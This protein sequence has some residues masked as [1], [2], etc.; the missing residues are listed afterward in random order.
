M[1]AGN[2]NQH[3]VPRFYLRYF[4]TPE[5]RESPHPQVWAF[6]IEKGDEYRTGTRNVAAERDLYAYCGSDLDKRF[7]DLEGMLSKHW[8]DL[9]CQD[10]A[11]DDGF[12]KA[13][14][15]F[16]CTLYLRHPD[17][18]KRQRT[19]RQM[20][21]RAVAT[22]PRDREGNST[23]NAVTIGGKTLRITPEDLEHLSDASEETVRQEWGNTIRGLTIELAQHLL[24][25]PWS[26][27]FT[28]QPSFVTS[29]HPVVLLHNTSAKPGFM[30]PGTSVYLPLST[31]RLLVVG[32]ANRQLKDG[33]IH[34]L[35]PP[36]VPF[37]NYHIFRAAR[38]YVFSAWDPIRVMAQI[39]E[40]GE[41]VRRESA[42]Q[43]LMPIGRNDPCRCGSGRKYK[44]C[45]GA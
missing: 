43:A 13:M 38:R 12:R 29:D 41:E 44:K 8:N 42:K 10:R 4:A 36:G 22:A 7:T 23:I 31:T 18:L 40:V 32:N 16:I 26:V 9:A 15:L 39:A 17:E 24:G 3:Y 27:L 5:S 21:A 30:A 14:S 45:C 20:W 2:R 1:A 33:H 19:N 6:P 28:R 37:V 25:L 11:L 35:A 34:E